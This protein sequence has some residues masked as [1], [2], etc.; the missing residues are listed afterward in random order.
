MC[1]LL[2]VIAI[3][4][5]LLLGVF[6]FIKFFTRETYN[7]FPFPIQLG[8]ENMN[9]NPAYDTLIDTGINKV[10]SANKTYLQIKKEIS[11]GKFKSLLEKVANTHKTDAG[12]LYILEKLPQKELP[13][14]ILTFNLVTKWI[15]G[16]ITEFYPA[17]KSEMDV[18]PQEDWQ[19][20]SLRENINYYKSNDNLENYNFHF[21]AFRNG[22]N[23]HFIVL[24]DI[25]IT[26]TNHKYINKLELVGLDIEENLVTQFGDYKRNVFYNYDINKLHCSLSNR[27]ECQQ[28]GRYKKEEEWLEEKR[29]ENRNNLFQGGYRCFY[30]DASSKQEC[31]SVDPKLGKG[32]WDK[33][34]EYDSQCPFF[35]S[36]GNVNYPNTRGKCME[37]GYCEL[38]VNV[39]GIGFRGYNDTNKEFAPYCHNCNEL[40][41]NCNG[42]NCNQCCSLQENADYAFSNDLLARLKHKKEIEDKELKVFDIKI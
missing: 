39:V 14:T 9:K 23:K 18:Y 31:E 17:F 27:K 7:N 10:I 37:S 29:K 20:I 11:K 12:T 35:G 32:Y 8:E 42:L 22:R 15:I 30:K 38:P 26:N 3:I 24:T 6:Y 40:V 5:I 28:R 4:L 21:R 36:K 41:E 1:N 34:C 2:L 13:R 19:I 16:Q 33:P 25:V